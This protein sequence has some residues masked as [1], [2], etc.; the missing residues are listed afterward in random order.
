VSKA[1]A[2]QICSL[3][4]GFRAYPQRIN[5]A[6]SL[7]G[8]NKLDSLSL[9]SFSSLAKLLWVRTE[10]ARVIPFSGSP[11]MS[12][13]CAYTQR[14]NQAKKFVR[15]KQP[16]SFVP[17]KLFH[18]SLIFVSKAGACQSCSLALGFCAYPQRIR[19]KKV[20]RDKHARS[21]VTCK[22][23]HPSLIFVSKAWTYPSKVGSGI[24]SK[25]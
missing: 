23:F 12:G 1:G 25:Y 10:P 8:T 19:L 20:V 16:R 22:L 9:A 21:F 13:F 24:G 15:D 17:C 3:V 4:V 6:K 2:C 11:L 5:Q 18:P 7:S 14:F